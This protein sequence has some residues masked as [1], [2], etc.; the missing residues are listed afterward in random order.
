MKDQ[1]KKIIFQAYPDIADLGNAGHQITKAKSKQALASYTL[2]DGLFKYKG[3]T[4]EFISD[5]KKLSFSQNDF[6]KK[7]KALRN[8]LI[9]GDIQLEDYAVSLLQ[10]KVRADQPIYYNHFKAHILSSMLRFDDSE[11]TQTKAFVSNL[12]NSLEFNLTN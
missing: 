10:L 8:S 12:F 3:F 9:L 6:K 2:K 11:N 4:E 1:M 5:A 7:Y